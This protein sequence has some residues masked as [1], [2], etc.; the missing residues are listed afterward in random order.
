[1]GRILKVAAWLVAGVVVVFALAAIALTLFFDPNDFR[2]DVSAA[3][4]EQTG[5][6]LVIDGDVSVSLFPWLAVKVGEAQLGDAP[7]FGGE[8]FAAFD[9]ASFSVRLMPLLFG[10]EIV[11][12]AADLDALK[13]NLKINASGISNWSEL[14]SRIERRRG[15]RE[16]WRECRDR[17]QSHRSHQCHDHLRERAN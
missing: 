13:L 17:H 3:V 11:V 5:R 9:S 2:E 7:G 6:E 14:V 4:F 1:M 16:W 12:G 8:P 15:C 10:Q